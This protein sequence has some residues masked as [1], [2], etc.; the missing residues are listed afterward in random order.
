MYQTHQ[1]DRYPLAPPIQSRYHSHSYLTKM[2]KPS[3][4]PNH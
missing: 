4:Y 1:T 2:L 3:V